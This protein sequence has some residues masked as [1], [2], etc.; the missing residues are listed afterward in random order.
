VEYRERLAAA[1]RLPGRPD[2]RE[3]LNSDREVLAARLVDRAL[4]PLLPPGF[5]YDTQVTCR[6]QQQ[7]QCL[8]GSS[9]SN[10]SLA[11]AAAIMDSNSSSYC[12]TAGAAAMAAMMSFF[13]SFHQ[14]LHSCQHAKLL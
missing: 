9:S 3:R 13:C 5:L 11:A 2:R 4:R 7:Q 1:G 10:A 12:S 8:P 14:H 6:Q